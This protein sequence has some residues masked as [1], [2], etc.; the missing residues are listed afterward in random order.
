MHL[1]ESQWVEFKRTH[2]NLQLHGDK[3]AE[4]QIAHWSGKVK[5]GYREDLGIFMRSAW[6]ANYCR[7]LNYFGVNWQ[8]EPREFWFPVKRGNRSYKP[9]I[10]LP[11][12]DKYVEVKGYLTPAG[13]TKLKRMAKYYSEVKIELVTEEQ[14]REIENK[15]GRMIP[16]WE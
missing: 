5:R 10:Y 3:P 4:K 15:L 2:P 16:G 6:E 11:D 13:R 12:E 7:Y 8:Y 14:Y 9:D 1:S